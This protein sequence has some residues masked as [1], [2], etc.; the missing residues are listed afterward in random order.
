MQ[1]T[2]TNTSSSALNGILLR[3]LV[4][5]FAALAATPAVGSA[6]A[7]GGSITTTTAG[8]RV[9]GAAAVITTNPFGAQAGCTL[10]DNFQDSTNTEGYATFQT[11]APTGTPGATTVGTTVSGS[12]VFCAMEVLASGGTIGTDASSPASVVNQAGVSAQTASF[13]PPTS[14][15][16]ALVASKGNAAGVTS[17]TVADTTSLTWTERVNINNN[18]D[19]YVGVWTAPATAA[20]PVAGLVPVTRGISMW[21]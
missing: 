9:Y 15:L 6:W 19:G 12:A 1:V 21:R 20:A 10:L 4:L 3:V 14:L 18:S 8:S 13:S 5:N 2:A 11:T 7:P 17:A 16:V